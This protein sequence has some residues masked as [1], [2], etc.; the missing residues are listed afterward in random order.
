MNGAEAPTIQLPQIKKC[1]PKSTFHSFHLLTQGH[2]QDHHDDKAD[3]DAVGSLAFIA[4]AMG[5]GYDFVANDKE[6]GASGQCQDKGQDGLEDLD[7]KDAK[8]G[9][10]GFDQAGKKGNKE[11]FFCGIA[12]PDQGQGHSQTFRHIL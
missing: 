5:F 12:L 1:R 10:N 4:V 6:H 3:D 2:I 8:K 7:Q 11:G 9:S